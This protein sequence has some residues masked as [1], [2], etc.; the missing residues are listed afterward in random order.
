MAGDKPIKFTLT[1]Q[2]AVAAALLVLNKQL[3]AKRSFRL[4]LWTILGLLLIAGLLDPSALRRPLLLAM[5]GMAIVLV[6]M[7]R[8][9][10]PFHAKRHFRQAAALRD[11]IE[12]TWDDEG[13]GFSGAHG[14]SRLVWGEFH[15]WAENDRLVLLYQSQMLY[16]IIPKRALT[17][18]Q[19]G[20]LRR[21]LEAAQVK[22]C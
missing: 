3:W 2:E 21:S 5:I 1:E 4:L 22:S 9:V 7:I 8:L 18:E 14:N 11:E 10:V 12:V 17:A 20:E 19:V 6:L 13:V 15:R 16:N